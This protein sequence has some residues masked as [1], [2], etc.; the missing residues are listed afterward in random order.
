ME[1]KTL[2]AEMEVN[3]FEKEYARYAKIAG[4]KP[5]ESAAAATPAAPAAT[6][7]YNRKTG[8]VE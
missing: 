3:L 1:N 8:K 5:A 2:L 7:K 6:F 4:V